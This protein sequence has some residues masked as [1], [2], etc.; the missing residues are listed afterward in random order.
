MDPFDVY[1]S[2][3]VGFDEN[4]VIFISEDLIS[5]LIGSYRWGS[6]VFFYSC[7]YVSKTK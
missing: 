6:R 4:Y 7:I 3:Y 5:M 1:F 2:E